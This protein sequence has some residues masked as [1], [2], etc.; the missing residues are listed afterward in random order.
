LT[1]TVHICEYFSGSI[2]PG[3]SGGQNTKWVYQ[4]SI[5]RYFESLIK[6]SCR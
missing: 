5:Y 4:F 3:V 1:L 6:S 2:E